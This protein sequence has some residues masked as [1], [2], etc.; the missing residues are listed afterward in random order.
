MLQHQGTQCQFQDLLVALTLVF[1]SKF[2]YLKIARTRGTQYLANI[3][4]RKLVPC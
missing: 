4:K 2:G 3:D 1:N